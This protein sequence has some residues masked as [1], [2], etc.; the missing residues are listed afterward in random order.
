MTREELLRLSSIELIEIIMRLQE[1]V[2][3]LETQVASLQESLEQVLKPEKTS[4]NSSVPPSKSYKPNRKPC[5]GQKPLGPKLGHVGRSRTRQTPDV[6]IECKPTVCAQC[7]HDLTKVEQA[8]IGKSQV[9]DIPPIEPIV[10][11]AHRFCATCPSCGHAQAA[12]YPLVLEP[13]RV[14]GP[15]VETLVTYFHHVHHLSY[16]RLEQVL[17]EVFGLQ[18]SQGAIDNILQRTA[19]RLEP[20][21]EEIRQTVQSSRVVG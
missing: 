14:F 9:V 10:V 6:V 21:A 11:E 13:E 3:S 15:Q 20:E 19:Q 18:I 7:G 5:E 16:E 4:R 12:D 1:R 2:V 8:V 17:S